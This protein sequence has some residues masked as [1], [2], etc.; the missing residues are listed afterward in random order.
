[1]YRI[2]CCNEYHEVHTLPCNLSTEWLHEDESEL[3]SFHNSPREKWKQVKRAQSDVSES[4][5]CR[6][7]PKRLGI[8]CISICIFYSF[9]KRSLKIMTNFRKNCNNFEFDI[10]L[11]NILNILKSIRT[12]SNKA[13]KNS[14]FIVSAMFIHYLL[15]KVHFPKKSTFTLFIWEFT[16]CSLGKKVFGICS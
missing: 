14:N 3:Q 12:V 1:M 10:F 5:W 16:A 8:S 9:Q 6:W 11:I 7:C 2:S 4:T 15:Y 13:F